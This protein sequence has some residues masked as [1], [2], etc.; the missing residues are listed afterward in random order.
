[1]C[2]ALL[3]GKTVQVLMQAGGHAAAARQ[4][5]NCPLVNSGHMPHGQHLHSSTRPCRATYLRS[6]PRACL[7]FNSRTHWNILTPACVPSYRSRRQSWHYSRQP[8]L[9]PAIT[10]QS[11]T[12]KHLHTIPEHHGVS[13]HLRMDGKRAELLRQRMA[14]TA[15]PTS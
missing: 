15:S 1:M 11:P 2:A 14:A 3:K 8:S 13:Q 4:V 9:L 6:R 7:Q 12:T 5:G 10:I